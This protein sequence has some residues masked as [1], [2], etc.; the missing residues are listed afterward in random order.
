MTT[1]RLEEFAVLASILNY[2]K[3]AEKLF[4]SQPI[5]SRHIKELERELGASLFVRD[6][7]GVVLTDEGKFLLKWVQPLLEK[8]ERAV[9]A[10]SDEHA[11]GKGKIHITCSEQS[12]STHILAFIRSFIEGYPDIQLD[13]AP[14]M[15]GS[16]KE[17]IYSC[18]IFL[19]PCDF[20]DMLR[21][22]AEG[23]YLKAQQPLLAIPPFHHFGDM[24]E[25]RLEDLK[26]EDLI[27]PFADEMFGPYARN[28]LAT[29]R[30]CHGTLRKIGA[31][32]A[33]AGLL[34]VELGVG[35]MLIPHHLKHRVYPQTRTI[36]VVDADCVFPIYAYLNH[37]TGN[38]AAELFFEKLCEEFKTK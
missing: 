19:T 13:L 21:R 27:V 8:T 17:L 1:E 26:G 3:A 38:L 33:Q 31:E 6:T 10:L 25:I 12:L 11:G 16:K 20:L 30:K 5:L 32:S 36:P 24:Q 29:A 14:I 9:S 18:D 4:I 34:M 2:S 23:V 7:H 28:A 15:T 35:V 37:S 22:D